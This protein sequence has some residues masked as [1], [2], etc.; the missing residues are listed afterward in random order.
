MVLMCTMAIIKFN[1]IYDLSVSS[2]KD[3]HH[4]SKETTE[5]E[6][7]TMASLIT[8]VVLCVFINTI[9]AAPVKEQ[10]Y[11]ANDVH[12]RAKMQ[13]NQ[14]ISA[15]LSTMLRN[16]F[17]SFGPT[18]QGDAHAKIQSNNAKFSSNN[19]LKNLLGYLISVNEAN[20]QTG[21]TDGVDSQGAMIEAIDSLPA[22]T[23]REILENLFRVGFKLFSG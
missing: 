15:L 2:F 7:K 18:H 16:L 22:E 21:F 6:N 8:C 5:S 9:S 20:M 1:Q 10:T 12:T 3:F 23:K 19:I 11:L 13:S 17:S 14:M 4:Q